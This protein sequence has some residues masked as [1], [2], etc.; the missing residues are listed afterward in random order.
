MERCGEGLTLEIRLRKDKPTKAERLGLEYVESKIAK[1]GEVPTY[2]IVW[3]D[4]KES[5]VTFGTVEVRRRSRLKLA[6]SHCGVSELE[7]GWKY[8]HLDAEGK[9][10]NH[11]CPAC[12]RPTEYLNGEPLR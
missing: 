2:T 4:H 9:S 10:V 8:V 1:T 5:T 12:G 7:T 3:P 11:I 6:C